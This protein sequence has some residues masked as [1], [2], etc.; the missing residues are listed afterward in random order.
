MAYAVQFDLFEPNDEES[1]TRQE[2]NLVKKE[3]TNVR[4]GM[5]ARLDALKKE[6]EFKFNQ[7]QDELDHLRKKLEAKAEMLDFTTSLRSKNVSTASSSS[8]R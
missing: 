3:L 4:R 7:Q 2:L 8:K 1:L 5:F 6:F